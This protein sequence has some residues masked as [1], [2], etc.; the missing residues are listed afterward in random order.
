MDPTRSSYQAVWTNAFEI[1]LKP[2]CEA[3]D[4]LELKIVVMPHAEF[5]T[6]GRDHS[7]HVRICKTICRSRD[8]EIAIG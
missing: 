8:S 3:V 7:D 1:G 5:G 6:E 2:P 4:E